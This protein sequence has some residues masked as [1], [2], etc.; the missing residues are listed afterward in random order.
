MKK[1]FEGEHGFTKWLSSYLDGATVKRGVMHPQLEVGERFTLEVEREA[2]QPEK[3]DTR[4]DIG[5]FHDIKFDLRCSPREK[6]VTPPT[7]PAYIECKM[8]DAYREPSQ[9][10]TNRMDTGIPELQRC[11]SDQLQS[12]QRGNNEL[13]YRRRYNR[14]EQW[15]VFVTCPFMLD[16]VLHEKNIAGFS[17]EQFEQ[18]LRGL[19]LGWVFRHRNGIV[20][21]MDSNNSYL[22]VDN[23]TEA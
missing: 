21:Q 11:F 22:V 9:V 17:V 19:G 2:E 13:Q 3:D 15:T 7:N 4:P 23:S 16:G 14:D 8:G 18:T 5:V 10:I 6:Y 1:Q 12:Y 20:L